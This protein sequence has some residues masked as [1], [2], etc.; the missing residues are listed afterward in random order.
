MRPS[1][2]IFMGVAGSGKTTVAALFA[3]LTGAVFHEGDEFHPPENV[4]KMRRGIP[5]NDAD[6]G[7][8]LKKLREIIVRSL[9][10]NRLTV[11]TCSALKAK[12]RD[13][14]SD[15]DPRVK[16]V[17]LA[18][19]RALIAERLKKRAGHFMPPSLLESQLAALEPPAD[20]FVFSCEKPP[21]EIAEELVRRISG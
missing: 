19:S 1:V 12:Y 6:R 3:N 16:F 15:G 2:L 17:H 20:A 8:W 14:L 7:G 9:A 13:E 11:V 18:G 10:G 5:L 4:E 21:R